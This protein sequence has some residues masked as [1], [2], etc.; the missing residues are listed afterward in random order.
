MN[1]MKEK[2][3][4]ESYNYKGTYITEDYVLSNMVKSFVKDY[5]EFGESTADLYKTLFML[6]DDVRLDLIQENIEYITEM[7]ENSKTPFLFEDAFNNI[8]SINE[9]RVNPA[10][11]AAYD[12]KLQELLLVGTPMDTA[13]SK[14]A[15]F[16]YS[17]FPELNASSSETAAAEA[18]ARARRAGASS[19]LKPD[20]EESTLRQQIKTSA[21][22]RP[23]LPEPEVNPLDSTDAPASVKA[24]TKAADASDRVVGGRTFTDT[25]TGSASSSAPSI[26]KK[27]EDMT[28]VNPEGYKTTSAFDAL[29]P[30]KPIAADIP[31]T[32]TAMVAQ[33]NA[34]MA[35][36]TPEA[37]MAAA[38]TTP[39]AAAAGVADA[40]AK[41]GGILGWIRKAFTSVK[42]FFTGGIKSVGEAVKS[43][44]WGALLKIP[45]I[46][47]AL[48]TGGAVLA[49]KILKKL[50]GKKITPQRE[51]E[52]QA[53]LKAAR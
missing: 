34:I 31:A 2:I 29:D 23:R 15:N 30:S 17:Q 19:Q 20:G 5:K 35:A 33:T 1:K 53:S 51:A 10:A 28:P 9:E 46:K 25:M 36:K 8:N 27:L 18:P 4:R 12:K 43:G 40:G 14:A 52:L 16:A 44:N 22:D 47:G 48:I 3:L 7:V 39:T 24:M 38:T 32:P 26:P 41:T 49:F 42:G 50:F 45:L 13:Q 11:K 21:G 37:A 6:G